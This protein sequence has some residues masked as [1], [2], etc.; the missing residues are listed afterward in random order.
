MTKCVSLC[1]LPLVCAVRLYVQLMTAFQKSFS[2]TW[3]NFKLC[4]M[5][6][7]ANIWGWF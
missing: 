1:L 2:Q 4:I 3:A 7:G 6:G 5:V